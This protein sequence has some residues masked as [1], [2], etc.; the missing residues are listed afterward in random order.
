LVHA[1][2]FKLCARLRQRLVW[3][4]TTS[5][6]QGRPI[7]ARAIW[8]NGASL[9]GAERL[10]RGGLRKRQARTMA[11]FPPYVAPMCGFVR[12]ATKV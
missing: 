3:K 7:A 2:M 10:S 12:S 5:P 6:G 11:G 1:A 9:Q 8:V 4:T